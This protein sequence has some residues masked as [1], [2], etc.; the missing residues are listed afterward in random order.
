MKNSGNC[1]NLQRI[2]LGMFVLHSIEKIVAIFDTIQSMC[3][4]K[5][6][7]IVINLNTLD[8]NYSEILCQ[9]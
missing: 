3:F 1:K 5:C 4:I 6:I 2:E 7:G 9:I 8:G